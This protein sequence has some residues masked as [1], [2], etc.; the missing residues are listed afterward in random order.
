V[1]TNH[2]LIHYLALAVIV[3]YFS[4]CSATQ[5]VPENELGDGRYAFKQPGTPSEKIY[6]KIIEDSLIITGEESN[7]RII[8]IA[9]KEQIFYKTSLDVDVMTILFKYRPSVAGFPRQLNTNFNGNIFMGYRQDRY[10]LKLKR[11]RSGTKKELYHFG[12][13]VGAFAGIGS[14][15][16]SS[17]TTNYQTTDEYDGFILIRGLSAMLA[18][19]NI[20]VGAAIGW[21][22]LTD[23][24]KNIWIYQNKPWLGLTLSLNLN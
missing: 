4:S 6:L 3:I 7:E 11:S 5:K 15:F 23:R 14:T 12:Y 17:W 21:D 18:V 1:V 9:G 2:E 20:T 19:N 24:D 22:Y 16:V 10:D 8:P 13:T